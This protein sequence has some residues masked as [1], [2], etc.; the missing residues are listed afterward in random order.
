[1]DKHRENGH[2]LLISA[3]GAVIFMVVYCMAHMG[4]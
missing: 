2:Y 1:M 4:F 3:M